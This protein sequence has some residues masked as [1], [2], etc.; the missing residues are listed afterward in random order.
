VFNPFYSEL[1]ALL[2]SHNRQFKTT[3]Q[4]AFWDNFKLFADGYADADGSNSITSRKAINLARLLCHLIITFH[5][6]LSSLKP[7]DMSELSAP[8]ILFLATLFF[9]LFSSNVS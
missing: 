8:M 6:S 3:F 7:I 4:F 5:L 1:A 9:A 2:C